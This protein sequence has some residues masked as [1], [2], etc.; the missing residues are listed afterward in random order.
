[1]GLS[2]DSSSSEE[3]SL[4]RELNARKIRREKEQAERQATQESLLLAQRMPTP[5]DTQDDS[6]DEEEL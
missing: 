5:P 6:E 2:S 4:D 1:M 3:D